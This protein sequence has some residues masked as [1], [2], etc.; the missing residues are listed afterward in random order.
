LGFGEQMLLTSIFGSSK[1]ENEIQISLNPTMSFWQLN[2]EKSNEI[3]VACFCSVV[4][5]LVLV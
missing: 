2:S 3:V 1:F 4:C 5:I